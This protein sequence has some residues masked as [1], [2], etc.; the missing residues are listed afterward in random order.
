[1]AKNVSEHTVLREKMAEFGDKY[2]STKIE[3]GTAFDVNGN[4]VL[5][6]IGTKDKIYFTVDDSVL[7]RNR[8]L[9]FIHNHPNGSSFSVDDV[10]TAGHH[11]F[12][13]ISVVG[14][15][16]RYTIS[17]KTPGKWPSVPNT[18]AAYQVQMDR[19]ED[20][21]YQNIPPLT[22]QEAWNEVTH[23]IWR[24]LADDFNLVYERILI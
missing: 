14:S 3:R 5:S 12:K 20:W 24:N 19:Y 16:Y 17:P 10:L 9:T 15:K 21:F 23:K 2:G 13:E 8:N 18:K 6:K 7:M 22:R 11:N 1:M 4:E